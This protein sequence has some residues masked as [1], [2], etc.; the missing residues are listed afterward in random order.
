MNARRVLLIDAD[1]RRP[2]IRDVSD[3]PSVLGLS[4]GLRAK[5]DQKLTVLQ[6]T[7]S[8]ALLPAGRP[9]PDPT[10][11]LTSA[12]MGRIGCLTSSSKRR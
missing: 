6:V 2:S 7:K 11:G 5:T 1:L 10:S 3:M 8:L 9:D 4:E 12:R